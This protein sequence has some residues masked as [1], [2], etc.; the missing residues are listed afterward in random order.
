MISS[1]SNRRA[2][3]NRLPC[4]ILLDV[5]FEHQRG[6]RESKSRSSGKG[7]FSIM[8]TPGLLAGINSIN[9]RNSLRALIPS[10]S[11]V[12]QVLIYF[13]ALFLVALAIFARAV[14]FRRQ[15]HRR[16]SH[17][18]RPRPASK[19]HRQPEVLPHHRTLAET[20]GLPPIRNEQQPPSPV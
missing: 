5:V 3:E 15:R 9:A 20:G 17:H 6:R 16:H 12:S 4:S 14:I 7:N 13:G 2:V 19:H 8:M 11:T 1:G 18:H 10:G